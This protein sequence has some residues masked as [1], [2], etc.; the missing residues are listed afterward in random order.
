ML[1]FGIPDLWSPPTY[2]AG[3][4]RLDSRALFRHCDSFVSVA[5]SQRRDRNVFDVTLVTSIARST[6]GTG[7]DSDMDVRVGRCS[8]KLSLMKLQ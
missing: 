6:V 7:D 4:P 1:Q 8:F 2:R 5:S 3:W